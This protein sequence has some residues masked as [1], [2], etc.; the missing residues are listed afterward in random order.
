MFENMSIHKRMNYL[1]SMSTFA[2]LSATLFVFWSMS[3]IESEYKNLRH[4][5]MSAGFSVLKIEKGLNYVSRTTRDSCL[6]GI[7]IKT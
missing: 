6:V 4:N 7:M 3:N 5:S 1:I 2:I